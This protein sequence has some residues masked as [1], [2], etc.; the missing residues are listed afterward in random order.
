ML[1]LFIPSYNR[2]STMTTPQALQQAGVRAF[3]VVVRSTQAKQYAA[4]VGAKRLLVIGPNDGLNA[5]REAMRQQLRRGDWCLAMDDDIT[6]WIQPDKKFYR[7]HQEIP[8]Q[9]DETMV[10]RA[11][12]Q[13]TMNQKVPF[14]AFYDLIVED[15][16]ALAEKEGAYLAGFSPHE[17]PAF[18]AKKWSRCGY[19]CGGS[20]LLRN[21]GLPWNQTKA[22]SCEDYALTAAHLYENGRVLINKWGHPCWTAIYSAGG[23]GPYE[24]RLAAMTAAQQDLLKR[25]GALLGAKNQ[26]APEKRQGE[27][28]IRFNSLD[29]VAAWRAAMTV[30]PNYRVKSVRK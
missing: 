17:N 27:L 9:P 29:Q 11:R 5:A 16:V 25:Y 23:C 7:T 21:Q 20:M 28:R 26:N 2:A 19:V 4:V 13:P 8:L 10:T 30:D 14:T 18:R 24:E 3:T 1:K 6:G 12:W 22:S 15:T